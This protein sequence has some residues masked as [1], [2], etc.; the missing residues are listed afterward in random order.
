MTVSADEKIDA[1]DCKDTRAAL[2]RAVDSSDLHSYER[3]ASAMSFSKHSRGHPSN[4]QTSLTHTWIGE[5]RT[6]IVLK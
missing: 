6:F 3:L 5:K 4:T 1:V 2:Y